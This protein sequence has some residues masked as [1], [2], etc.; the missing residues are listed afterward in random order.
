MMQAW[1]VRKALFNA[2][3]D[4]TIYVHPGRELCLLGR[5]RRLRKAMDGTR[6]ASQVWGE[7]GRTAMDD[8]HWEC[9]AATPNVFYLP[10]SPGIPAVDED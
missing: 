10:A 6:K 3:L 2:G 7:L 5:C 4:E 1:D 9:L 8:G